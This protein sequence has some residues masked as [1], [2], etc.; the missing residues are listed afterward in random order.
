MIKTEI[1]ASNIDLDVTLAVPLSLIVNEAVCNAYKHAFVTLNEGNIFVGIEIE[2]DTTYTLTVKDNGIGLPSNFNTTKL[3]SIGFDLI[4]G[5]TKQ[6][7]GR[8]DVNTDEGT[9]IIITLLN[10]AY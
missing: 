1:S 3:K 9:E 2:N 10:N 6:L 5:L 4:K 8:L 7:K